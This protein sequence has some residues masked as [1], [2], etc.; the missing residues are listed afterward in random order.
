MMEIE[1][2]FSD[3]IPT[4]IVSWLSLLVIIGVIH[5]IINGV[6]LLEI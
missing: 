6:I 4:M 3:V 5:L 2:L 1:S